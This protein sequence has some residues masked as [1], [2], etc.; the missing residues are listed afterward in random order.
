MLRQS[1]A[2]GLL[3]IV[4]AAETAPDL[5]T[6]FPTLTQT[7][8]AGFQQI[9]TLDGL[10]EISPLKGSGVYDSE[11]WLAVG[12]TD[13]LQL[14]DINTL[15]P[16]GPPC[17]V[18]PETDP[19]PVDEMRDFVSSPSGRLLAVLAD[20]G[21]IQVRDTTRLEAS[22]GP[23]F[24]EAAPEPVAPYGLG[25]FRGIAFRSDDHLV[26][27]RAAA[28]ADAK[29]ERAF[30]LRVW[31]I[32]KP[33]ADGPESEREFTGIYA[34]LTADGEW[35]V[36]FLD[37]RSL[38]AHS[39]S[40]VGTSQTAET[41]L[42]GATSQATHR[43]VVAIGYWGSSVT[44]FNAT[45]G[46]LHSVEAHDYVSALPHLYPLV[47]SPTGNTLATSYANEV[48]LWDISSREMVG[49][50]LPQPGWPSAIAL[51]HDDRYVAIAVDN[52]LSVWEAETGLRLVGPVHH[53]APIVK[54]IF[55]P[56]NA[57]TVLAQSQDGFLR[58]WHIVDSPSYVR[59]LTDDNP[60]R[61]TV[62]PDG[63]W[64]AVV[65]DGIVRLWDTRTLLPARDVVVPG[66]S[67]QYVAFDATGRLM[68]VSAIPSWEDRDYH[69]QVW[70]VDAGKPLWDPIQCRETTGLTFTPD[71]S[72]L[73]SAGYTPAAEAYAGV[74]QSWDARTGR[75]LM[76]PYFASFLPARASSVS[77][78]PLLPLTA[79]GSF[80][81]TTRIW[82]Q[83]AQSLTDTLLRHTAR[84]LT[85]RF[86][87]DGAL[88]ATGAQNALAQLWDHEAGVPVGPPLR[89]G[90]PV[91]HVAFDAQGTYLATASQDDAVRI[92]EVATGEMVGPPLMLDGSVRTVEF[93]ADGKRLFIASSTG[94]YVWTLPEP[95]S[96][97]EEMR[98]RTLRALGAK[99]RDGAIVSMSEDEW[100]TLG[101]SRAADTSE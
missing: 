52:M 78:H 58:A 2:L 35:V 5:D 87:P 1:N 90:A 14:W 64:L 17:P 32:S 46:A 71:G 75:A 10:V 50:P 11:E 99:L 13:G 80:D 3:H 91:R 60:A 79:L 82:D 97:V 16:L 62:S 40:Q 92:W 9:P 26:T 21:S 42:D 15:A 48:R 85:T 69:V 19:G 43:S 36:I 61:A 86:S 12:T 41:G 68:A 96:S 81:L 76:K 49:I 55:H 95:P 73:V 94:L 31:D 6:E 101:A 98:Q 29:M 88:L 56:R 34:S 24:T 67:C 8:S 45:T 57:D 100:A 25:S 59:R 47:I 39:T 77:A 74:I 51:S 23:I 30:R 93:G 22:D 54:V 65:G 28:D 70:D 53:P 83:D 63:Q 33:A 72:T 27:V 4:D 44:I 38:V 66:L 7:W 89:H 20:D 84:V 37:A 18:T